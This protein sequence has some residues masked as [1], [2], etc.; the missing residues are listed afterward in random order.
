[1]KARCICSCSLF[2]LTAVS[3]CDNHCI[4]HSTSITMPEA[5]A[6]NQGGSRVAA[7]L[8]GHSLGEF[9][10]DLAAKG[11]ASQK[12]SRPEKLIT[13]AGTSSVGDGLK[14]KP[15]QVL[16]PLLQ[17]K[18]AHMQLSAW[19]EH[20]HDDCAWTV[21]CSSTGS[22]SISLHFWQRS[23]LIAWS[24]GL[25]VQQCSLSLLLW[26]GSIY[27]QDCMK[28]NL[29]QPGEGYWRCSI[30]QQHPV[31]VLAEH[32]ILSA[33]V[34]DTEKGLYA[35]FFDCSDACRGVISREPPLVQAQLSGIVTA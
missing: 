29:S 20:S 16:A 27:K 34:L 1:M 25:G 9:V 22:P 14:V 26:H 31:Q 8:R 21:E 19:V 7:F 2:G 10:D 12:R 28:R 23:Y 11:A 35:G 4:V 13:L 24:A 18:V 33:P 32:R 17:G 3:L 5:P 15:C 6:N 30:L